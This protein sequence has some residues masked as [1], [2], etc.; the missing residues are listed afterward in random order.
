MARALYRLPQLFDMSHQQVGPALQEI[1]RGKSK[2]LPARDNDSNAASVSLIISHLFDGSTL[3]FR[4][5]G[6]AGLEAAMKL[7]DEISTGS[8]LECGL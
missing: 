3:P 8:V 4:L 1:Q 2:S 7:L 6:L 5:R